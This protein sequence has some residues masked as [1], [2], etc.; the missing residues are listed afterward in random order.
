MANT[1][2]K[3]SFAISYGLGG[4]PLHARHLNRLLHKAGF[5][6]TRQLKEADIIIAHSGGC[7]LIP[8]TAKPQLV[9]YVGMCLA[10]SQPFRTWL[11]AKA[12]M[13]KQSRRARR[14]STMIKNVY[15]N[16][17]QPLRN[18]NMIRQSKTARPIVFPDCPT[19]FISNRYDPWPRSSQTQEYLDNYDWAFISLSGS[20]DDIWEHPER[21]VAIINHYARL[22]V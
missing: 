16:L 6:Q 11:A 3:F 10:Q 13:R 17:A 5:Q 12:L 15:Y 14:L 21:Y 1:N 18:I 22:L 2:S 7:W 8:K 4:G 20:H 19:V 9:I